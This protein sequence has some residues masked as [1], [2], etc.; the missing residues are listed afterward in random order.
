MTTADPTGAGEPLDDL[1]RTILDEL[2]AVY[3]E[4]EPIPADL[5]TRVRFAVDLEDIDLE[6]FRLT[7]TRP[8]GVRG[9]QQRRTVT[10][11]SADLSLMV[12]ITEQ[13]DSTLLIDGWVAPAGHHQVELRTLGDRCCVVAD[14]H[15][16]FVLTGIRPGLAQFVVD[17]VPQPGDGRSRSFVTP[18][19]VL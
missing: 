18:S 8:V 1:D 15:G 16:R 7:E 4:T 6:L 10:F 12:S 9:E 13:A 11:D 3:S 2:R 14:E 17:P 19:I 5:L